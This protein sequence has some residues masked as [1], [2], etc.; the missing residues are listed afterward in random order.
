MLLWR[1]GDQ[2]RGKV[3]D[4]GS[5]NFVQ[6]TMTVAP[7]ATIYCAPEELSSNQ[8]PKVGNHLFQIRVLHDYLIGAQFGGLGLLLTIPNQ[9]GTFTNRVP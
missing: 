8:T 4:Y 2:W 3:S 1:Q 9:F 5:A 7:G 6:Q